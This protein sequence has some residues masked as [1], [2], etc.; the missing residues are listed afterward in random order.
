MI[1]KIFIY[2]DLK[3]RLISLKYL[4]KSSLLKLDTSLR[5]LILLTAFI[6]ESS[7]LS[8][9]LDSIKVL[10]K[11]SPEGANFILMETFIS[12]LRTKGLFHNSINFYLF[13]FEH[14]SK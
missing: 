12:S 8:L 1:K 6:A 9:P 11:I 7:N 3:T 10:D 14:N 13:F 4:S 5:K 2:L